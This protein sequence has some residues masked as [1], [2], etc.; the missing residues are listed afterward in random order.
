VIVGLA[1][2]RFGTIIQSAL[3]DQRLQ[4]GRS[5][6]LPT[7]PVNREAL[8]ALYGA[9]EAIPDVSERRFVHGNLGS[10]TR[11]ATIR[12]DVHAPRMEP[13]NVVDLAVIGLHLR[14]DR[15]TEPRLM[16][17]VIDGRRGTKR[18][19]TRSSGSRWH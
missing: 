18:A 8:A 7:K 12:M 5:Q 14:A 13:G 17:L 11:T 6:I 9:R 15:T 2:Q 4:D 10:L 3:Q 19:S 1:S 16:Q